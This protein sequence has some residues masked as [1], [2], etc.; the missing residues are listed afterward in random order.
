MRGG[1]FDGG[2]SAVRSLMLLSRNARSKGGVLS[3]DLANVCAFG[4]LVVGIFV[5]VH[6]LLRRKIVRAARISPAHMLPRVQP[7]FVSLT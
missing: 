2:I 7:P 1:E 4:E 3:C 5:L 6:V